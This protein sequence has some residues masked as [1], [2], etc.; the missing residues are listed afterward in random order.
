MQPHALLSCSF[1][2]GIPNHLYICV[3][4]D[5]RPFRRS[6]RQ[7]FHVLK[8]EAENRPTEASSEISKKKRTLSEEE[9]SNLENH[10]FNLGCPPSQ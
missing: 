2:L 1:L 5:Q 4:V 9:T 6:I 10:N 7:E 8:A 3:P